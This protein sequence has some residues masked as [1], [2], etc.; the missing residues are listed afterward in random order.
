MFFGKDLQ[1]MINLLH[2]TIKSID[3]LHSSIGDVNTKLDS[4]V[5]LLEGVNRRLDM[6]L[7]VCAGLIAVGVTVMVI[8][9][10]VKLLHRGE[11]R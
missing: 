1:E 9:Y 8:K 6:L 4:V 2:D 10:L 5:R 3:N 11:S 7:G